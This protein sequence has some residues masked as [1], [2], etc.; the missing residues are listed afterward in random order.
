MLA[1]Y[2]A[3]LRDRDTIHAICEDYRAGATFD[4]ELDA[5]DREAGRRIACPVLVLWSGLEDVDPFDPPAIWRR[6]ADD[7]RGERST[8]AT[9]SPRSC[10]DEAC[11]ALSDFFA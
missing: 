2:R 9:S 10:P 11:A 1:E 3:A 7:V 4:R 6:W 8:A 5:R